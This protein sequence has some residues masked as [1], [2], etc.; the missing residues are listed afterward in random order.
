MFDSSTKYFRHIP[1]FKLKKKN[2]V[3][4]DVS[5]FFLKTQSRKIGNLRK[6]NNNN[7][8]NII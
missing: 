1:H 3:L 8:K 6:K 2:R 7:S 5:W 4:I